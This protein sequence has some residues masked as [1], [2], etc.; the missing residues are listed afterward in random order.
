V[1]TPAQLTDFLDVD[2]VDDSLYPLWWLITLRGHTASKPPAYAGTTW[3][4]VVGN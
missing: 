4:S 3:T 1:W 2:S